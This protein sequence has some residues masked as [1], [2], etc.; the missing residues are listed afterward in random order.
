MSEINIDDLQ[1]EISAAEMYLQQKPS[2]SSSTRSSLAFSGERGSTDSLNKADTSSKQV[3]I[4]APASAEGSAALG[5]DI[6]Q[7]NRILLKSQREEI[8]ASRE[9]AVDY[10]HPSS[11]S[12]SSGSHHSHHR[13]PVRSSGSG[14]GRSPHNKYDDPS[15][16][17]K[18]IAKLLEEHGRSSEKSRQQRQHEGEVSS[19]TRLSGSTVSLVGQA[20]PSRPATA[21]IGRY[22]AYEESRRAREGSLGS[23]D[24]IESYS[25]AFE[26][27]GAGL[28]SPGRGKE[29]SIGFRGHGQMHPEQGQEDTLFFA[30]DLNGSDIPS[31]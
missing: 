23:S 26:A 18:L 17:D 9:A 10:M 14:M 1:R 2:A 13:S 7:L 21:T 16:R 30:S 31:V 6:M 5:T 24:G 28:G 27:A 8:E 4:E 25:A 15:E 20:S 11:L 12:N 29:G 22:Q 3:A 19:P